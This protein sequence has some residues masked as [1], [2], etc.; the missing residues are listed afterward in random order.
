MAA[1][2]VVTFPSS[3]MSACIT[4][5]NAAVKLKKHHRAVFVRE[6]VEQWVVLNF[7][8]I[9]RHGPTGKKAALGWTDPVVEKRFPSKLESVG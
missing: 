7:H 4:L 2:R 1:R 5:G 9:C 6:S 3:F 8:G